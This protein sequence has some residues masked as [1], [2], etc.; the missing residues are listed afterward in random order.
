[1]NKLSFTG[2]LLASA[3]LMPHMAVAQEGEQPL[4]RDTLSASEDEEIVVQGQ[5]PRGSVVG[6]FQPELTMNPGDVRALGVSDISELVSELTPQLTSGRGGQPVVLLEGRRVSSFREIATI[7]TEAIQRVEI[8]P[9]EVALKYGY[10]ADQKVMNIV[11]RRR[12]RAFTLEGKDRIATA[13]GANQAE[14]EVGFLAIRRNGRLNLNAE[15]QRTESLLESE[16]GVVNPVT[17]AD[18]RRTSIPSGKQLTITGTY[19]R[20]LAPWLNSSLNL[21][22]VTD[23]SAALTGPS[24]FTDSGA[25]ARSGSAQTARVGS[26]LNADGKAWRG[27]LTTTYTHDES[28]TLTQ[29]DYLLNNMTDV[30]RSRTD[31]AATDLT[32]NGNL[33]RL[34]AGEISLTARIGGSYNGFESESTRAT[35]YNM[36][37]LDRSIGVGS[38]SLDLPLV[39]SSSPFIGKLSA[40]GNVEVQ[41]L[42]DF[43]TIKGYGFG[44]NW[45]PRNGV[46]LIASFKGAET[47]PTVQQLGNPTIV[48]QNV[49]VFDYQKGETVNITQ[50]SGGNRGLREA[51]QNDMRLGLTLKPFGTKTDLTFSLDYNRRVARNGVGSLPGT[52]DA[53]EAAFGT[54]FSDEPNLGQ[55][56]ER[57]RATGELV[58]I[59]TRSIN[60]AR[61]ENSSIRW[62]LNFTKTLKTPQSLIDAMRAEREKRFPNGM[63]PNFGRG[64]EGGP[65]PGEGGGEGGPRPDGNPGGQQGGQQGGQSGGGTGGSATSAV[66]GSLGGGANTGGAR[67]GGGAGGPGGGFGGGP[68]GPGGGGGFG[69]GPGGGPGGGGRIQFAVY[70]TVNLTD[71]VRLAAMLPELNLLNGD[72]LGERAGQPRHEIEVQS[73]FSQAGF[74][75]RLTGKWEGATRVV[76]TAGTPTSNLR[77]S[78]LATFNL[79]LF[80]N[81]GARPELVGKMPWLRGARIQLGVNNI[82][83][84]RQSVTDGTGATP[85]AYRPGLVDPLGRTITLS[86]RKQLF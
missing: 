28:R 54:R 20:P 53:S 11:L 35:V 36:A 18:T 16:R 37:T 55:R 63:P 19:A 66:A 71:K 64:G 49:Q 6:D 17:G 72:T 83:N 4:R 32:V 33:H 26:T 58:S 24:R 59:D 45:R 82:F 76:G 60:I 23:Q 25:L 8:L 38:L 9:E 67:T 29:R 41:S 81:L 50:T 14:G 80:A 75:A 30:G 65:P 13:G 2:A 57:N 40:N 52:T 39:K 10:P 3:A 73:G 34:P 12:F 68:G 44:L 22:L 85:L 5:R 46:A 43:G 74:G 21:E 47:A 86:L 48:T 61:R 27:T 51:E 70:H 42:S 31:L 77:F 1:M 69:R 56:F 84:T 7:P 78:S 15:Y 79:R 62:G